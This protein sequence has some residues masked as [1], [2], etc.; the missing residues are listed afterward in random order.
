MVHVMAGQDL[1]VLDLEQRHA[2]LPTVHEALPGGLVFHRQAQDVQI[3]PLRPSQVPDVQYNVVDSCHLE[4]GLPSSALCV[5][6]HPAVLI[7]F[8]PAAPSD[9]GQKTEDASV[10]GPLSYVSERSRTQGGMA[11]R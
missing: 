7:S 10:F 8:P 11:R 4:H 1:P 6:P 2:L 5:P 9:A 3:K